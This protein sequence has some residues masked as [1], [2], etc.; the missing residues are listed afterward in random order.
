MNEK[1]LIDP[2]IIRGPGCCSNCGGRLTIIDMESSF[3][4]MSDSGQLI[5][6]ETLTSCEGVCR[7]CG[8]RIPFRPY[9]NSYVRDNQY[10]RILE[11][12]RNEEIQNSI[13]AKM[14]ELKPKE[15]N[16]FCINTKS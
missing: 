4:D 2:M 11:K 10:T 6:E 15:D 9:G 3:L 13:K 12:L 7:N 8:K 5:K 16:P 1:E 14:D